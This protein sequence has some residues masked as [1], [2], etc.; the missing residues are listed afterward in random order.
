MHSTEAITNDM[1]TSMIFRVFIRSEIV[2]NVKKRSDIY[3]YEGA[4]FLIIWTVKANIQTD[5]EY[6]TIMNE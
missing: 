5:D 6:R 1:L 4:L 3:N 2:N